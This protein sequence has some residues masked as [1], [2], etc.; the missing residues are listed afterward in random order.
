MENVMSPN[1]IICS[2]MLFDKY[3]QLDI[4]SIYLE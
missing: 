1:T 2:L 4:H 3:W